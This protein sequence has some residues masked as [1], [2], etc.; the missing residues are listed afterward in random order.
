VST[1]LPS[2]LGDRRRLA[3]LAERPR[4]GV[5]VVVPGDPGGPTT[6]R[7]IGFREDGWLQVEG[8]D[9]PVLPDRLDVPEARLVV[10]LLEA[11]TQHGDVAPDARFE[12]DVRRPAPPPPPAPVLGATSGTVPPDAAVPPPP[13]PPPAFPAPVVGPP[14]APD[15]SDAPPH[16]TAAPTADLT[17]DPR[18]M[19]AAP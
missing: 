5:A 11:A 10:S 7:T 17:A 19:P 14:P 6:G 15:A 16:P 12:D 18:D 3:A 9:L 8:V 2:D 4:A 13:P 1:V